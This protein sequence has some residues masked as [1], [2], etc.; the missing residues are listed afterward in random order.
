MT[1]RMPVLL[2]LACAALM[3]AAWR[4]HEADDE[5]AVMWARQQSYSGVP[6]S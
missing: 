3:L 6:A 2:L 4:G 1:R 5:R